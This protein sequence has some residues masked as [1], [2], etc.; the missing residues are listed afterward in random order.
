MEKYQK[1]I[2]KVPHIEFIHVSLDFENKDALKW[3]AADSLP[4]LTVLPDDLE[5]SGL[6][7]YK[8]NK[9]QPEYALVDKAG[10]ALVPRS[11]D[12]YDAFEKIKELNK[13]ALQK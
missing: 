1:T 7:A 9:L 4:W 6:L 10:K 8:E 2:A 12:G 3:A 5:K 11:S 13:K